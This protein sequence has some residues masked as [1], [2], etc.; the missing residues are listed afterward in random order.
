MHLA[1]A[2]AWPA[3]ILHHSSCFSFVQGGE[4]LMSSWQSLTRGC[5]GLTLI[6][7]GCDAPEDIT[8][9]SPPGTVLPRTP[10]DANNPAQAQGESA[11]ATSIQGESS[12]TPAYTPAL[13][14]AK[15]ETKKTKN[16][17][18]YET[19]KEGTGDELK[20]G[21]VAVFHYEGTLE[22]GTIFDST[23][24][25]GKPYKVA[26][27]TGQLIKGWEEGLPGMRVG[28]TRKLWVPAKM[29]YGEIERPKIPSGSN[30]IF[31]VELLEVLN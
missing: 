11:V 20:P 19:L 18:K 6:L 3:L 14:T 26:M 9:T 21:R 10:P 29:A 12:K 13:P 7:V 5:L 16:G 27:G 24:Q 25:R 17:V 23:R 8:P 30:L 22:N 31:E 15:G 28:E 4:K 1:S 2:T